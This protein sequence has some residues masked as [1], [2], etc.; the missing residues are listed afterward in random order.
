MPS[1]NK[2]T[3]N[4]LVETV[5]NKV[6]PAKL[7]DALHKI[8]VDLNKTYE[9]LFDGPL[10]VNNG[11]NLNLTELPRTS[12]P[13][14]IAFIDVANVFSQNQTI[15]KTRPELDLKDSVTNAVVCRLQKHAGNNGGFLLNMYYDGA[16]WQVDTAADGAGVLLGLGA[17]SSIQR[18]GGVNYSSWLITTDKIFRLGE[19]PTVVNAAADEFVMKNN[20]AL[21]ACNAAGNGTLPF[22]KID[23]NDIVQL[24]SKSVG[25]TNP[26]GMPAIPTVV[27]A[28]IS[29]AGAANNGAIVIEKTLNR[30]VFYN[31]G[32]RYY[33][34]G[35][36]F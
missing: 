35:T 31:N 23:T 1:V 4:S 20:K 5:K 11:K 10:P 36:A 25:N 15:D 14:G 24:G 19:P 22:A 16:A 27:T 34:A 26:N 2:A 12:L 7:Y 6:E 29:A 3:I 32:L 28:D 9:A 8:H 18:I 17:V 13:A 30:L 33:V 21:R